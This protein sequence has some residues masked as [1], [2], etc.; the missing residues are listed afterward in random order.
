MKAHKKSRS[1]ITSLSTR[2][3]AAYTAAAAATG[4]AAAGSAEADI[5]YSGIIDQNVGGRNGRFTVPV[6]SGGAVIAFRHFEHVY[7]SS[8]FHDGGSASFSIY[9]ASGGAA[10]VPLIHTLQLS[11]SKLSAREAISTQ[12]FPGNR[13]FLVQRSNGG[14][15]ER[16]QFQDRGY[17]FV[18]FKFNSGAGDQYGWAR[19]RMLGFPDNR[20]I[21][22]DLA[23]AD[24]GESIVAGQK[25]EPGLAMESLGG[26]ALGATA[27]LA[28]RE[29]RPA[30]TR[31]HP[32]T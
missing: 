28:W 22:V 5:H 17:G 19:V 26:L 11:I 13:G 10:G 23:Y 18:G 2:R 32:L 24:P 31:H 30:I 20:F 21:V 25:S 4:F 7:G 12:S 27:L 3:C 9:G 6:G 16:G 8:S 14:G 15:F 29:S 1:K